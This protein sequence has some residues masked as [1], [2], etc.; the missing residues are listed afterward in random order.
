ML[1]WHNANPSSPTTVTSLVN[2]WLRR[3][4]NLIHDISIK[5]SQLL[6]S[7]GPTRDQLQNLPPTLWL[8]RQNLACRSRCN[9]SCRLPSSRAATSHSHTPTH[10]IKPS[11]KHH[12]TLRNTNSHVFSKTQECMA[13]NV[14]WWQ[15]SLPSSQPP[16]TAWHKPQLLTWHTPEGRNGPMPERLRR[17]SIAATIMRKCTHLQNPGNT[18]CCFNHLPPAAPWSLTSSVP[19]HHDSPPPNGR[20]HTA[21]ISSQLMQLQHAA[22]SRTARAWP[23]SAQTAVAMTLPIH[24]LRST[25]RLLHPLCSTANPAPSAQTP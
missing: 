2:T 25:F 11:R 7:C 21:P 15:P 8:T 17:R 6:R 12:P 16:P 20:A 4:H 14:Q 24:I 22:T 18:R 13:L 19:R 1:R 23:F 10:G 9:V 5:L 3:G